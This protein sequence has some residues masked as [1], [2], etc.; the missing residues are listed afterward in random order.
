MMKIASLIF[1]VLI[2][3]SLWSFGHTPT[4]E[5]KDLS[6]DMKDIVP[7]K[8]WKKVLVIYYSLD[9]NT[10][11]IACRIQKMIN[12]DMFEIETA[13]TYPHIPACYLK[14]K[15]QL[16]NNELP[17]LKGEIPDISDYDLIIIGSPV[18][19]YTLSAPMISFLSKCDF[20]GKTVVTFA[21]HGG[22]LGNFFDDFRKRIKNAKVID[23]IDF[24]NVSGQ[25]SGILN[26]KISNWLNELKKQK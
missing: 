4:R 13:E 5:R 9:G 3:Y 23:G 25:E 20:R 7:D 21:T 11:N 14:A 2:G 16:K 24:K 12:A 15:K 6:A 18:W 19:W 1:A 22:G 10:Y 8:S 17:Q 26:E